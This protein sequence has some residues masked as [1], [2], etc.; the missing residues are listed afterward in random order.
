[1][2]V[3]LTCRVC[4]LGTPQDKMGQ[5]RA[6]RCKSLTGVREMLPDDAHER[7][8]LANVHLGVTEC[9]TGER[10]LL[11]Q[12]TSREALVRAVFASCKLPRSFHPL[13]LRRRSTYPES[14]GTVCDGVSYVD[15]A[16]SGNAFPAPQHQGSTLRVSPFAAPEEALLLCPARPARASNGMPNFGLGRR[17]VLGLPVHVCLSNLHLLQGLHVKFSFN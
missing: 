12:F 14:E 4:K 3:G 15:G 7:A 17:D 10:A 1:M 9:K 13:G 2:Q 5:R 16:L 8:R 6:V 11:N